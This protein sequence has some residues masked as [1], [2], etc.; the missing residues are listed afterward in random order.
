MANAPVNIEGII[1]AFNIEL[2]KNADLR[3]GV[4][5]EIRKKKDGRYKIS[6]K[7][8]D[9]Y[10]RKRFTMA[11]ELGHFVLHGAM[12]GDGVDDNVKYRSTPEGN[13]YNPNITTREETEA[14]QFAA[15]M[16]MPE[17]LLLPRVRETRGEFD[18]QFIKDLATEFQVS[19]QAMKIRLDAL[20]NNQGDDAPSSPQ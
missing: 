7:K 3:E 4:L 16:L 2:E 19:P 14:N 8:T 20:K 11:H 12:I 17:N 1:R 6:I 5:G 9:H 10:F 13:F 15:S 18:N